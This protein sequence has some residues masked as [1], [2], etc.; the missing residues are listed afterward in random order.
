SSG[1]QR[2]DRE[3]AGGHVRPGH[4]RSAE[5]RFRVEP[6][7]GERLWTEPDARAVYSCG[8]R[9]LLPP[10]RR[11]PGTLR[12]GDQWADVREPTVRRRRRAGARRGGE[13]RTRTRR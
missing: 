11:E 5:G 3:L 2:A 4:H 10:F 9:E 6:P 7:A 12:R 13:V 8:R 1:V